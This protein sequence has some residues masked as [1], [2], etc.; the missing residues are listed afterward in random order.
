MNTSIKQSLIKQ[1]FKPLFIDNGKGR[2]FALYFPTESPPKGA[3]LYLSPFAEEMNRCRALAAEQARSL[4]A[5]GYASLLLDPYGVGDSDGELTA[6]DWQTWVSDVQIAADWLVAQAGCE[7]ILWG[8]RLGALLA[9]SIAN[10]HPGRFR[11]LLLWQPV[12]DGKVFMTQYLRLRL[13]FLMERGLP[14]ETT[15]QIR[16]KLAVG[17]IVEVAGYAL[18]GKLIAGIDA[19][20]M[21]DLVC[22][23]NHHSVAWFEQV[24]QS[25]DPCSAQSQRV[26]D[27]LRSYGN[28]VNVQPF[29]GPKFWQLHERDSVP[30][31]IRKTNGIFRSWM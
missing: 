11:R 4:A 28:D 15:D 7:T 22:L 26:I 13:A 6:V 2:L 12:I 23:N 8:C 3:L 19:T 9:T 29:T 27:H 21:T 18:T 1:S 31:L 24:A 20:R 10:D 14:K 5:L 30:D 25:G 16:A 17:E